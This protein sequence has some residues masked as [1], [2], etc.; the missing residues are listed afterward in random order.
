MV[1]ALGAERVLFGSDAPYRDPQDTIRSV[2]AARIS[3]DAKERILYRNA[4][5]LIDRYSNV[6]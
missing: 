6:L 1:R 2:E 3:D 4:I 5:E